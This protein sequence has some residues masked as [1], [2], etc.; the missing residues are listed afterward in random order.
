MK[1][2]FI[3]YFLSTMSLFS[4]S[5]KVLYK[6]YP[7]QTEL[8]PED[9]NEF[10]KLI[11]E[12]EIEFNLDIYENT[13]YFSAINGIN[14]DQMIQKIVLAFVDYKPTFTDLKHSKI[15]KEIDSHIVVYNLNQKWV[16]IN[17]SKTI[18][19][20]QVFKAILNEP[21]INSKGEQKLRTI[22]AWYCPMI[23][24]S[25]GPLNY[26]GLPGLILELQTNGNTFL[27]KAFEKN[28]SKKIPFV[29]PNKNVI[30]E[31]DFVKLNKGKH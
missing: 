30:N 5:K 31:E 21:F 29:I 17:E 2:N 15:Y 28:K 22:V 11:N 20:Y 13:S 4:Q 3:L 19:N 10:V 24:H 23:P 16:I 8:N 12:S 26:G 6:L 7:K 9:F 25:F 18:D 27:I 14:E 1:K